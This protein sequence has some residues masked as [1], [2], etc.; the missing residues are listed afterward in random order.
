LKGGSVT[1]T[2]ARGWFKSSRSN[3]NG[4]CVEINLDALGTVAVRDSK[5]QEAAAL[6]LPM[7]SWSG[8]LAVIR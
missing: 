2:A 1:G 3:P 8:F 6:A 5:N 4:S 7:S